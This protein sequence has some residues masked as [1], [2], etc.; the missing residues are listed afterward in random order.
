MQV[1]DRVLVPRSSGKMTPGRI[2]EVYVAPGSR[3]LPD[4]W[5]KVELDQLGRRG[6]ALG[7]FVP[8]NEL[9]P[10]SEDD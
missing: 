8:M 4:S 1:G 10:L 9:V 6:Q 5:V 2:V 3:V 7:K